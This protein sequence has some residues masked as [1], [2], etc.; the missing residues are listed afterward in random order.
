MS[1]NDE[2]YKRCYR[3]SGESINEN[4]RKEIDLL[5]GK[6]VIQCIVTIRVEWEI[7]AMFLRTFIRDI[8]VKIHQYDLSL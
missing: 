5:L 4:L 6:N 3:S 8:Q 1:F 2:I 7:E